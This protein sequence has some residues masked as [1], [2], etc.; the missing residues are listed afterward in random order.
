M[1]ALSAPLLVQTIANKSLCLYLYQ[2]YVRRVGIKFVFDHFDL[3]RD[4]VVFRPEV[5]DNQYRFRSGLTLQ[6]PQLEEIAVTTFGRAIRPHQVQQSGGRYFT[7]QRTVRASK[8]ALSKSQPIPVTPASS[9]T[10]S[11]S[12]ASVAT[13][14]AGVAAAGSATVAEAPRKRTTDEKVYHGAKNFLDKTCPVHVRRSGIRQ[15]D[16][17]RHS[18]LQD[19]PWTMQYQVDNE[20][21]SS[22]TDG[23]TDRSSVAGSNRNP[24]FFNVRQHIYHSPLQAGS[25][26]AGAP[27][28]DHVAVRSSSQNGA[29]ISPTEHSLESAEYGALSSSV[30][31]AVA[32][33]QS[34]TPGSGPRYLRFLMFECSMKFLDPKRATRNIIRRWIE[35]KVQRWKKVL[36]GMRHTAAN[37]PQ[38]HIAMSDSMQGKVEYGRMVTKGMPHCHSSS[39]LIESWDRTDRNYEPEELLNLPSSSSTGHPI[40]QGLRSLEASEFR[41]STVKAF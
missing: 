33:K 28:A 19:Y 15:V 38:Q 39:E 24:F 29:P 3:A 37:G 30:S 6:N 12:S 8:Q 14:S 22:S 9:S 23:N 2:E 20:Q 35:G 21:L 36:G 41:P 17:T 10:T 26:D 13:D 7:V 18:F 11:T 27:E 1:R 5:A 32:G 16:G 31:Q 4:R 40:Q 25:Q 34:G